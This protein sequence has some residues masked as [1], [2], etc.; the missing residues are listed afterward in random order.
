L[1]EETSQ[2]REQ[3]NYP[4]YEEEGEQPPQQLRNGVI[5]SSVPPAIP[6]G[7]GRSEIPAVLYSMEVMWNR[8]YI[9]ASA[10]ALGVV[11]GAC[12]YTPRFLTYIDEIHPRNVTTMVVKW[13]QDYTGRPPDH[14]S[15]AAS[16]EMLDYVYHHYRYEDMPEF[17]H[18]D[19]VKELAKQR[20]ETLRVMQEWIDASS[21][22]R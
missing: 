17:Q 1:R 7:D 22:P 5:G 6:V 9:I 12:V 20:Q 3:P 10:L 21:I 19:A 11:V 18:L 2:Q 8:K 16:K 14:A 15:V 13:R 4:S